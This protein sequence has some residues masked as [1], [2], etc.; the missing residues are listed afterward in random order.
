[1]RCELPLLAANNK[2]STMIDEFNRW[3]RRTLTWLA[4]TCLIV[5]TRFKRPRSDS[6]RP[7]RIALSMGTFNPIHLWHLQVAQCAWEQHNLDFTLFIPN[8]DPPHKEGVVPAWLRYKMVRAAIRGN[9]RFKASR[10]EID[11]PGKSYTVDTLRALKKRYG[12][13]VELNL[14]IGLD[15]L[16]GIKRWREADEIFKLARILVAPRN[17]A[18]I[19]REQIAAEL[20]EYAQFEIIDCPNSDISSTTIR[21][22]IKSGRM[23]SAF[24]VVPNAVRKIMI[25]YRLYR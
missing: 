9:P 6:S 1:L 4:L 15:N 22:W 21:N 11:R 16:E 13:D 23:Y 14:I 10:I 3:V 17:T 19:T 25:R 2:E 20:P 12:D 8:G 24:Y 18:T 5:A 7:L